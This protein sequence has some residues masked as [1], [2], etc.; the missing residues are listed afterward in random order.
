MLHLLPGLRGHV[1]RVDPDMVIVHVLLRVELPNL[2]PI[3]GELYQLSGVRPRGELESNVF[4][5]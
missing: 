5:E 3:R 1:L 2:A 4:Q